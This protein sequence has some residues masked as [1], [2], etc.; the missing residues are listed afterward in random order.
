MNINLPFKPK[1]R[2]LIL[3]G[4]KTC[5]SRTRSY[6]QAGDTFRLDEKEFIVTSIIQEPLRV[7]AGYRHQREGFSNPDEFISYWKKLHP[8]K[9]YD[10]D[11]LVFVHFFREVLK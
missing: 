9:G 3:A 1:M 10:P 7:I 2:E 4:R 6:G 5:T 11:Q 8:T